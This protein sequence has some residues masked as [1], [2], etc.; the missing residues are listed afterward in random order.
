MPKLTPEHLK[1]RLRLLPLL[2]VEE[3]LIRKLI[4]AGSP[5]FEA[6]HLAHITNVPVDSLKEKEVAVNSHFAWKNMFNKM[7]GGRASFESQSVDWDD[8]DVRVVFDV[9]MWLR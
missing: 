6:S 1:L 3:V 8:P 7:M 9:T 5:D 2:Q 4:P